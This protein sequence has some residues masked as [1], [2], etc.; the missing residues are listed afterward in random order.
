MSVY[1]K[2]NKLEKKLKTK[3]KRENEWSRN[4]E[5]GKKRN[6]EFKKTQTKQRKK[7]KKADNEKKATVYPSKHHNA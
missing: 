3:S 5:K 4:E 7:G 6:Y 1:K 2:Q